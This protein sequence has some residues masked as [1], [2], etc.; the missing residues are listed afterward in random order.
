MRQPVSRRVYRLLPILYCALALLLAAPARA[1]ED[2]PSNL[3]MA[4]P[5]ADAVILSLQEVL[6]AAL[7]HN[8]DIAVRRYDPLMMGARVT[9]AEHQRSGRR[10][11]RR[12]GQQ[13]EGLST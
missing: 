2:E 11:S 8:L 7:E 10:L 4:E 13:W 9:A 5:P 6:N 1:Q 3:T 12:P